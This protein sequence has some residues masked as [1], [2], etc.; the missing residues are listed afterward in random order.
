MKYRR[1]LPLL[2]PVLWL[3]VLVITSLPGGL[4]Y[5]MQGSKRKTVETDEAAGG[6]LS[7]PGLRP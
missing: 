5:L 6:V 2:M 1:W 3:A 4:I 7:S